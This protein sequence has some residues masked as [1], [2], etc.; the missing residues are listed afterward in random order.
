ML[1]PFTEEGCIDFKGLETLTEFYIASGASGLF[2]NCL[3]GEMFQLSPEERIS[4]TG[5]V[6]RF[7]ADRVPVVSTGT[8]S[9]NIKKNVDFISRISDLGV[10][11]TVVNTNQICE[12]SDRED[13]F[14]SQLEKL[15]EASGTM[16]LGIYECPVPYKRLLSNNLIAWLAN[17]GRFSYFKDTCCDNEQIRA[18]LSVSENSPLGLY[19]AHT[20][21]GLQSLRDGAA[22]LS[23]IGANFY[24]ELY[25]Y[26]YSHAGLE[27]TPEFEQ[28]KD[29]LSFNDPVLHTLYPYSAKFFLQSRGLPLSTY[30]RTYIPK[31][32]DE[33]IIR[34]H[35]LL[36]KMEEIFE[37][38]NMKNECR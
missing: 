15:I 16:A 22:G 17:S 4:L 19:N 34:L 20:P 28:V 18:R 38:A 33:E 37:T 3:S 2:T 21:S 12:V 23:P 24:P 25:S 14:F 32:Q 30:I 1:T 5:A 13:V 31:A 11:C 29:F 35:K 7:A 9:K 10:A 26:L 6:V 8:F 36:T 27:E